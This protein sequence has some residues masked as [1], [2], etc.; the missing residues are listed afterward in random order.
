MM[1]FPGGEDA[2]RAEFFD[3]LK[4]LDRQTQIQR[5]DELDA[6]VRS[7]GMASLSVEEKDELRALK[8]AVSAA[9]PR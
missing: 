1:E 4:Q 5:R 2:W 8:V 3:A 6:R 7:G 9:P